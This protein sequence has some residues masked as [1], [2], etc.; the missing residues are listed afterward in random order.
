MYFCFSAD[1]RVAFRELRSSVRV[2]I[3]LFQRKLRPVIP[4]LLQ[5]LRPRPLP[6][7]SPGGCAGTQARCV[8]LLCWGPWWG[9]G[10]LPA[11]G[12]GCGPPG[13]GLP[14]PALPLPLVR[15]LNHSWPG[16][17][18]ASSK[19]SSLFLSYLFYAG[20]ST[21]PRVGGPRAHGEGPELCTP[22]PGDWG[23]TPPW[24]GGPSAARREA[25]LSW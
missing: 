1:F 6:A 24:D 20:R 19:Y 7:A 21:H 17:P 11:E 9:R 13:L 16:G 22:A 25:L 8:P 10:L 15:C 3:I 5:G 14:S 2:V 4:R 23:A 18:T 12:R